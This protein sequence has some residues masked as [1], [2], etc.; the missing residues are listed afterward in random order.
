ME[1]VSVDHGGLYVFVSEEFLDGAD[2]CPE[3]QVLGIVITLQEMGGEGMK[4][5]VRRDAFV[6]FPWYRPPGQVCETG[7]LAACLTAF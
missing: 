1:D 3:P 5:G 6:Y 7:G 2:T 4:K